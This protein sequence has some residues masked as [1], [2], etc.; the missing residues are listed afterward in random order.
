MRRR[1]RRRPAQ[2]SAPE[3]RRAAIPCNGVGPGLTSVPK[4][5][6]GAGRGAASPTV[7]PEP[8]HRGRSRAMAKA[9]VPPVALAET[10]AGP[11]SVL[12]VV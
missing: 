7:P 2:D 8:R 10:P 12:M 5:S 1:R 11:K 9:A 3:N 4:A 6:R